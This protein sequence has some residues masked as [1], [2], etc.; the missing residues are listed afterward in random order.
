MKLTTTL[1]AAAALACLA[2]ADQAAGIDHGMDPAMPMRASAAAS[3]RAAMTDGE[4]RKIDKDAGKLTLRHGP[5]ANLDMGA[6]T[7]V[8]RVADPKMLD[9]LSVG[10]KVRFAAD[11]VK[12]AL[13]VT[14]IEPAR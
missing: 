9:G 14:H 10:Q 3:T 12:G 5:I 11:H 7:M 1:T 2:A 6:M 13:T 4:V 8:Y